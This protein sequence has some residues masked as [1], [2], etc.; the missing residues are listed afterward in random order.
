[1]SLLATISNIVIYFAYLSMKSVPKIWSLEF[2][3]LG[4]VLE[5]KDPYYIICDEVREGKSGFLG[6]FL[7]P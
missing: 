6:F 3:Y 2:V 1:M 4:P 7:S 5:C